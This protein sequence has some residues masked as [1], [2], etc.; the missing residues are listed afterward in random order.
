M[1]RRKINF[2]YPNKSDFGGGS[3]SVGGYCYE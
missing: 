3:N 1:N 2:F